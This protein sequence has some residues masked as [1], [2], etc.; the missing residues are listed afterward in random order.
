MLSRVTPAYR[1]LSAKYIGMLFIL[2]MLRFTFA[3]RTI[4]MIKII[5]VSKATSMLYSNFS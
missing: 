3:I 5:S 2:F 1:Y 4:H